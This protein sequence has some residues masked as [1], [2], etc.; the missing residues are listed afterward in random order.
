LTTGEAVPVTI[1]FRMRLTAPPTAAS[2]A[3]VALPATFSVVFSGR[4]LERGTRL[5]LAGAEVSARRNALTLVSTASDD[6]GHFELRMTQPVSQLDADSDAATDGS[7]GAG[8]V[9]HFMLEAIPVG[10]EP[11]QADVHMVPGE[12]REEIFYLERV[13]GGYTTVVRAERVRREVTRQV[14]A[15]EVVQSVAGTQGD[16][17][18]VVQNLPGVARPSFGGGAPVLRGASPA[19]SRIFLEG[20][21][22]PIL[23]HFGGLR[24]TFNSVFLDSVEFVP[25]NFAPDYGRATGGIINVKVR[26]PAA[27][28]LRGQVDINLYDAGVAL[29][30]PLSEHW[31][32]GGA[33][34]RSYIDSILPLVLSKD[35]PLSFDSAPRYYDYQL[36]ASYKPSKDHTLRILWYGSLDK[37]EILFARPASDPT[38]RGALAAQIM[39][40]NVQI[41][42]EATLMPGLR[43]ES[44]IR[45]GYQQLHTAIGPEIFFNLDSFLFGGRSA[46][47]YEVTSWLNARAGIDIL[48]N[49]TH[50]SLNSGQRP[51]EGE[52]SPPI[53]T[54]QTVGLDTTALFYNPAAFF[55]LE[56]TPLSG[57]SI[58]PSVRFDWYRE[59]QRWTVDPRLS[60]RYQVAEQTALAAGAGMYSQPPGPDQSSPVAGN[61]GLLAPRSV[62]TSVG[63][64]QRL[65][66]VLEL[67]AT[68][69]YKWIDQLVVRNPAVF[70]DPQALQYL[71]TGRGRIY[72]I[73]LLVRATIPDR[74]TGW[75]AYTYQRSFRTDR[76]GASER[77]F[78]FDQ[79]HILTLL[80]TYTIGWG[81]SAGLRFRLV[82][83]N[84]TTPV[85]ASVY[86]AGKGIF[87]PVYGP[88]NSARLATFHQLDLRVDKVWTFDAWKLGAYLDIQNVYNHKNPEGVTYNFDYSRSQ[89]ATGLPIIPIVGVRGEW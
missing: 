25:G 42:D 51:T 83:G 23:Y 68:G 86:D 12:E 5:A 27:D 24:S 33:F 46:W 78:D 39:F 88:I 15:K 9:F 80:G 41:T 38:I 79:P 11:L 64:E 75:I 34:R 67:Q 20:Q 43:H 50:L 57:L 62:H 21:E 89:P 37:V 28:L 69:F 29:E 8:R 22:I 60:V 58:Q 87:V 52:T 14:I 32:I 71:N 6:Q 73:E 4:L 59:I 36:L 63:V 30:G 40:H 44:S 18:K 31:S 85:I 53:G 76:A 48:I 1:T 2:T 3:L 74:F 84:P 13:A 19:D 65:W 45:F 72:G 17:L 82:S 77:L 35:A 61:P 47:S 49:D 54:Q 66:E 16:T 10:H 70:S 7:A 26:D 56:M 81:L 55:G